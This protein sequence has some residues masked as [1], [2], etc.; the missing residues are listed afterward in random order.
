MGKRLSGLWIY[1]KKIFWLQGSGELIVERATEYFLFPEK[2]KLKA[3]IDL[4]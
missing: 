1:G 2:T 3:A 4:H